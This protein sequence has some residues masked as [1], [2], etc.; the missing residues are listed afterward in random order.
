MTADLPAMPLMEHLKE[1]RTRLLWSVGAVVLGMLLSMVIVGPVI[2]GL[3]AMCEACGIQTTR[4]TAGF[5]AYFQVA[6]RLGLL[7]ASPVILYQIAAFILPALHPSERRYMYLLVPGGVLLFALGMAFGYYIALP[8]TV[9]FLATFTMGLGAAPNWTLD[10]YLAL[11][12]N[13][14]V[15]L[16]VAFQTP[17]FVYVLAKVG[18]VTPGFMAHYRRY[19]IILAAVIAA[20]L[21]PTPDPFTMFLVFLP[22]LVLYELGLL[23]ARFL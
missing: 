10:E 19:F 21:T 8:R 12:T 2:E 23:M 1:L 13:L 5:V 17:L 6:L 9:T 16:G 11:V 20:V 18:I 22:M 4:P 15:V 14:L 3:T 7:F